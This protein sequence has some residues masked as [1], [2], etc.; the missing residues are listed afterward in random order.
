VIGFAVL[1]AVLMLVIKH[2]TDAADWVRGIGHVVGST[3]DGLST[4]FQRLAAG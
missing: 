1:A 3:L 2:P 4:F